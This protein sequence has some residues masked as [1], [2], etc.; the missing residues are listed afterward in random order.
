MAVP[1]ST[2]KAA[3]GNVNLEFV[4]TLLS[5]VSGQPTFPSKYPLNMEALQQYYGFMFYKHVLKANVKDGLLNVTG[6][7][8]RGYISVGNQ[9]APVPV[10]V[11]QRERNITLTLTASAG[12]ILY[13]LVENQGRVGYGNRMNYN[14]KGL[15]ANVTLDGQNL[16]DW[17]HIPVSLTRDDIGHLHS[18]QKQIVF[19]RSAD[20]Y[21]LPALYKGV[22][23]VKGQPQDTY[24]DMSLWTKGQVFING[25]N[26]GRYWPHKGPQVRLYVPKYVL[27]EG[28]NTVV[29]LELEKSPCQSS[30][31]CYINFTDK[32]LVNGSVTPIFDSTLKGNKVKAPKESII[33]PQGR[34]G[35]LFQYD[36]DLD[37][38]DKGQQESGEVFNQHRIDPNG[39]VKQ[40]PKPSTFKRIVV[41]VIDMIFVYVNKFTFGYL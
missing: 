23:E 33:Y 26:L 34:S 2:P 18:N 4:E 39:N 22:L 32:P 11:V 31:Q 3:Y 29:F 10:G 21:E 16:T 28:S 36:L 41:T 38:S 13:I 1:P 37:L 8:D 20:E 25:E 7:R 12:D 14:T 17:V 5:Y 27:Q 40:K 9:E 30:Q 24:L 6:V 19:R 15:I 35:P